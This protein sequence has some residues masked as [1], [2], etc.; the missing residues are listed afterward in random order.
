MCIRDSPRG[1]V[2]AAQDLLAPGGLFLLEHADVQG[3]ATRALVAGPAWEQARTV[4]DLTGRDRVLS[5]RR[6]T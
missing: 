5:A 6:G 4:A 1:V 3:A 2:A